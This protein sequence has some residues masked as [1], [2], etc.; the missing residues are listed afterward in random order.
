[1]RFKSMPYLGGI[2]VTCLALLCPAAVA[3]EPGPFAGFNGQWIGTGKIK[4]ANG[5]EERVRCRAV[6]TEGDGGR[7][8]QQS[9]RCASD[10]YNFE[11][12]SDLESHGNQI[13][14]NWN[15]TTRNVGGTV[16]GRGKSGKI[17]VRVNNPSFS[18]DLTLVSQGDVQTVTI[19]SEGTQF[20]GASMSLRRS[21]RS[22]RDRE[23]QAPSAVVG[24]R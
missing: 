11:L 6:Y 14:G 10:S 5:A 20:T 1:M 2:I 16:S 19:R 3:A 17:E 22:A 21:G 24:G 8:L 15:E 18:A 23:R 4:L 7:A 9:F 13:T 12:R